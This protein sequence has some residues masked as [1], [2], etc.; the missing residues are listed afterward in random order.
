MVS[1]FETQNLFLTKTNLLSPC[2]SG[3]RPTLVCPCWLPFFVLI[4][5][6]SLESLVT[7][8]QDVLF[9]SAPQ[10]PYHLTWLLQG[11]KIIASQFQP[12]SIIT[13]GKALWITPFMVAEEVCV[14]VPTD[15]K[16]RASEKPGTRYTLKHLYHHPHL[17]TRPHL[18]KGSTASINRV[19]S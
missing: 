3:S 18:F 10:W 8:G 17:S 15:R 4:R 2:P 9:T 16:Q 7:Q 1:F 11:R 5:Q 12:V 6:Y 19:T 14:C 13:A